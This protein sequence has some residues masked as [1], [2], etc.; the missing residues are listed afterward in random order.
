MARILV[1]GCSIAGPT[2]A[3]WLSIS[4]HRVTIVERAPGPRPGG[5][6]IDVRG[7][8]LDVLARMGILEDARAK[9]TAMKGVSLVDAHGVETWRSE[10]GTL[11]GGKFASGDIEIL[12][13]DLSMLIFG[14]LSPDVE[15]IYDESI[16]NIEDRTD[17][18]LVTFQSGATRSFDLVIGADGPRSEVRNLV[19]GND[20]KFVH[21]LGVALAVFTAPNSLALKDWQI[22]HRQGKGGFLI[23][24]ARDNLELRVAFGFEIA[25]DEDRA[26][27]VAEQKKL[28][29]DRCAHYRWKIPELIKAAQAA[30]D[31][32][33][34]TVAQVR[35]DRWSKGRC[36]LVGDAAY[37]PSPF[38]GQGTS[39][40]MV[41]AYVLAS[42]LTGDPTQHAAAF[43]RYEA[44][45]RHYVEL[46]QAL[47]YLE[48]GDPKA[49]GLRES[50]KN[51]ICI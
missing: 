26:M 49:D 25:G 30:S 11:S 36:A 37:C 31:F 19:F 3:Y 9:R 28:L 12:R 33:C 41:G 22:A 6:A 35:M 17:Q 45:L 51:A 44:R 16:T 43:D 5:Q 15:V 42:E 50:A 46:N 27:D 21:S 13:D 1:S 47:A 34:G 4:R 14:K 24:T 48:D 23:Y 38:S 18:V 32:Y 39:L 10:E 29:A 40:A 7:S 2:V 20:P 8:A